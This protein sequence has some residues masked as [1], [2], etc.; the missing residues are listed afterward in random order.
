MQNLSRLEL[1][2]NKEKIEKIKN[3][4]VF[5]IGLGGVGGYTFETLVRSGIENITIVDG[6]TFEE[7]NLNRQIL[8]LTSK[9]NKNK[10]DV[11]E[12][13]AK[14]INENIKIKKITQVLTKENIYEIN[15]KEYDYVI[16]ACDT[17]DIKK[18]LIKITTKNNIKFIS[19]MG[20]GNKFHPELLKITTLD[21]TEYDPIARILRKYVKEEKINKKI[22]VVAS[23]E[24]PIK[25]NVTTIGS[26]AFVPGAAG[27]LLTSY[28]INDIVGES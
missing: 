22:K 28:V 21:K 17:L 15:F 19:S 10:T 26:N 7:S 20:T 12:E 8:S 5:L 18:E 25:T 13:R 9:I 24:K 3:T 6:D 23:T 11:A 27:L 2:T 14:E 16:D 4:N 1:I